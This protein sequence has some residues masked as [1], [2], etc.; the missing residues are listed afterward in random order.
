MGETDINFRSQ[1][2]SN[3]ENVLQWTLDMSHSIVTGNLAQNDRE[4]EFE[5][6]RDAH[7]PPVWA[8]Y[9][10]NLVFSWEMCLWDIESALDFV[11]M[12][13]F[14]YRILAVVYFNVQ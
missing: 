7:T 2:E 10:M 14:N 8:S 11:F 3:V 4:A 9:G 13:H 5:S 6:T 12:C 1:P